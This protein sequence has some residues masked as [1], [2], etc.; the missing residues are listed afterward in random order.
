M[1]FNDNTLCH[2]DTELDQLYKIQPLINQ[3]FANVYTPQQNIFV[4]ESLIN[5]SGRLAFKQFIPSNRAR[6]G[7]KMYTTCE[8][9]TGY[10][11]KFWIYERKDSHME[12]PQMSRLHGEQ[13]QYSLG[14]GVI[15]FQYGVPLICES[16][17]SSVPLF[18]H[19]YNL[20]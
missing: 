19:L 13:W 16:F 18:R 5:F 15:L 7:V 20:G 2:R 14:L 17:C 6:Y 12:P 3:K 1:H 11:Y 10:T 9:S 4:D 8:R